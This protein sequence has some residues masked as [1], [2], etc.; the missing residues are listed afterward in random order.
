[1]ENMI[2][3]MLFFVVIPGLGAIA[4]LVADHCRKD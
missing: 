3:P 4:I 2:V 1:M